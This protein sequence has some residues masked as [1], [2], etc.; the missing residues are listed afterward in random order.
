MSPFPTRSNGSSRTIATIARWLNRRRTST[1]AGR[2]RARRFATVARPGGLFQ[3]VRGAGEGEPGGPGHFDRAERRRV[4]VGHRHLEGP[5]GAARR[6]AGIADPVLRPQPQAA[7]AAE[8][9]EGYAFRAGPR[10]DAPRRPS[11]TPAAIFAA[12]PLLYLAENYH[13][14]RGGGRALQGSAGVPP[15]LGAGFRAGVHGPDR[16]RRS[17]AVECG[18]RSELFN[19][20]RREYPD[21]KV[22]DVP[23]GERADRGLFQMKNLQIGCIAARDRGQG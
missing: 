22:A 14:S 16:I 7:R 3:A 15:F 18:R 12:R 19:R 8:V 4:H 1:T 13:R 6:S 10:V 21:V 17:E 20:V 5:G 9:P 23:A 2:R 11:R